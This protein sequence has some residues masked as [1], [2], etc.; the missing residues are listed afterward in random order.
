MAK[1]SNYLILLFLRVTNIIPSPENQSIS[2][3]YPVRSQV[4]SFLDH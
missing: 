1:E 2:Y 3:R 4:L